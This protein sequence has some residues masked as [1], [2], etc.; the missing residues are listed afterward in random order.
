M[1]WWSPGS[2]YECNHILRYII[3]QFAFSS[4]GRKHEISKDAQQP[5]NLVPESIRNS[6]DV[7]PA[8]LMN[9]SGMRQLTLS[10]FFFFSLEVFFFL[11]VVVFVVVFCMAVMSSSAC[12]KRKC[13]QLWQNP[14]EPV[15]LLVSMVVPQAA[16]RA[17]LRARTPTTC[18]F[19]LIFLEQS[20]FF[21]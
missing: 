11:V 12:Q 14:P 2:V 16:P 19:S 5:H 15:T 4:R 8:L 13:L 17:S 9:V 7:L 6:L 20:L 3:Y 1:D 21:L 10:L 18:F